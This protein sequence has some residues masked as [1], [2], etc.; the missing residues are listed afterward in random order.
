M[1]GFQHIINSWMKFSYTAL[2]STCK[3]HHFK[4]FYLW[5]V[6]HTVLPVQM[7]WY[8]QRKTSGTLKICA[9]L[10]GFKKCMCVWMG[11]KGRCKA[12]ILG[13]RKHIFHLNTFAA[14][15]CFFYFIFKAMHYTWQDF[16]WAL[17]FALRYTVGFYKLGAAFVPPSCLSS[18]H[19]T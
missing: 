5:Y 8:R 13:I 1:L 4:H 15:L 3:L 12:N 16:Y 10:I 17:W 11:G 18:L 7:F 9:S 19:Y 14:V 2:H 6:H